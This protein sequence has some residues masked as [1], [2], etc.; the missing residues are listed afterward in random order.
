MWYPRIEFNT[1]RLGGFFWEYFYIFYHDAFSQKK[2]VVA[3]LKIE[4][5]YF[6][7][8]NIVKRL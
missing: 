1:Q 8:L 4:E 7:H 6:F 3:S 5:K 2:I